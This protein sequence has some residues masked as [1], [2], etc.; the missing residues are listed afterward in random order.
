MIIDR[1]YYAVPSGSK[2]LQ[3][4]YGENHYSVLSYRYCLLSV[5]Q[6]YTEYRK[7]LQ[8]VRWT[9]LP[10]PCQESLG[11]LRLLHQ[12]AFQT[13]QSYYPR[14]LIFQQEE[15]A[16]RNCLLI[17]SLGL[18]A[19]FGQ[20]RTMKKAADYCASNSLGADSPTIQC[21]LMHAT[22]DGHFTVCILTHNLRI[23]LLVTHR[24]LVINNYE[25]NPA[26]PIGRTP[27]CLFSVQY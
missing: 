9:E 2:V 8:F 17:S 19:S 24:I 22:Y 21:V 12:P 27:A 1:N 13:I 10:E 23:I 6:Y 25:K 18:R 5:P 26:E 3:I 7:L 15:M 16:L 11:T 20:S 14:Q 4:K